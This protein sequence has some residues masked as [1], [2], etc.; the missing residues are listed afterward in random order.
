LKKK[1][2]KEPL[3]FKDGFSVEKLRNMR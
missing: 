3:Q 1:V 2:R